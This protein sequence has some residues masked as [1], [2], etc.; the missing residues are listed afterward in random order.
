MQSQC[1]TPWGARERTGLRGGRSTRRHLCLA[2]LAPT[3]LLLGNARVCLVVDVV[4][5][6]VEVVRAR[7][8]ARAVGLGL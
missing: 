4:V 5:V 3:T 6:V 8:R 7:V 1:L 2:R